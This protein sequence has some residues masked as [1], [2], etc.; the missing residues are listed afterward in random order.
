MLFHDIIDTTL[1][2]HRLMASAEQRE[3]IAKTMAALMP[4]TD[5]AIEAG[6]RLMEFYSVPAP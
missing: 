1:R 6:R 2:H 3:C 5:A 4:D